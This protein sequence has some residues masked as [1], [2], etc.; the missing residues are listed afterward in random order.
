MQKQI[1]MDVTRRHGDG[2]IIDVTLTSDER[3]ASATAFHGTHGYTIQT[4]F[5][6][7]Y[8]NRIKIEDA[9]AAIFKE[10]A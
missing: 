6:E 5:S 10:I 1:I 8:E 2:M 9:V 7:L 4:N 3:V